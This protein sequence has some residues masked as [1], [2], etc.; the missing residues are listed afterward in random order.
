MFT[1]SQALLGEEFHGAE[2]GAAFGA[3]GATIAASA[4][5]GPLLGGLL[6]E[7]FGWQWIFLINLPIGI[8]AAVAGLAK[9]ARVA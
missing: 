6:T 5:V 9:L 2:R 3:W 7:D 1:T 8:L 4:A